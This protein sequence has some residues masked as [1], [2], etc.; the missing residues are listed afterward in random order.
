MD[1]SRRQ[2]NRLSAAVDVVY[3]NPFIWSLVKSAALFAV[4]VKVARECVGFDLTAPIAYG[5]KVDLFNSLKNLDKFS[6]P[7]NIS[8]LFYG[9]LALLAAAI[10]PPPLFPF[11][12]PLPMNSSFARPSSPSPPLPSPPLPS[13]APKFLE[14]NKANTNHIL[15]KKFSPSSRSFQMLYLNAQSIHAHLDEIHELVHVIASSETWLKPTLPSTVVEIHGYK[16]AHNNHIGKRGGGDSF[17][18]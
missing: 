14:D 15:S 8:K 3:N 4:G 7:A 10:P 11:S 2:K 9:F 6:C 16:L 13:T 12:I 17:L 5:T 1:S 18:E